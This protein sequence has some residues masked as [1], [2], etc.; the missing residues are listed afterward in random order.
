MLDTMEEWYIPDELELST[1]CWWHCFAFGPIFVSSSAGTSVSRHYPEF[2]SH[3][4]R[5]L[6]RL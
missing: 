1:A 6:E 4:A 2:R 5:S 3:Q